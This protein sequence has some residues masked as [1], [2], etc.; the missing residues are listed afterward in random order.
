MGHVWV[1]L[2]ELLELI[3][4]SP[5]ILHEKLYNK[6]PT[7]LDL[8][9]CIIPAYMCIACVLFC[10]L[11]PVV[12]I[13]ITPIMFMVE[14]ATMP[15]FGVWVI[16]DATFV[17]IMGVVFVCSCCVMIVL[18]F[19]MITWFNSSYSTSNNEVVATTKSDEENGTRT[20]TADNEPSCE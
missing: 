3:L 16:V 11:V 6:C 1:F 7:F 15:L 4:L 9:T 5:C 12:L 14:I 19:C 10:L 13:C 20:A 18:V 17:I 2:V 8:F